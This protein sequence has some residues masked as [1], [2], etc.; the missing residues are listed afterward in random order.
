MG[1][2]MKPQEGKKGRKIGR[3]LRSLCKKRYLGEQRW[4]KNKIKKVQRQANVEQQVITCKING[5]ETK[6]KPKV[7]I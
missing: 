1:E 5:V 7:K 6:F 3:N 2:R 4:I